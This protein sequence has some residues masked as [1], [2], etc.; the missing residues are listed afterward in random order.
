MDVQLVPPLGP[1]MLANLPILVF[2]SELSTMEKRHQ[3]LRF[4]DFLYGQ[5][6]LD[7]RI[8]SDH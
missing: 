4:V 2:I 3:S 6:D 1:G 7:L 5:K 8:E